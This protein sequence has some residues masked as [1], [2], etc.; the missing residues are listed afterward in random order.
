MLATLITL[1][2]R[3][4]FEIRPSSVVTKTPS[5]FGT[6]IMFNSGNRGGNYSS[7][8]EITPQWWKL[9]LNGGN[10]SSMLKISNIRK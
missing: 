3:W 1:S 4:E 6:K 10:Y 8:V 7:M 2:L 5:F 9:L